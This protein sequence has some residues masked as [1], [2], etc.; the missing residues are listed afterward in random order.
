MARPK[1]NTRI[2]SQ[3]RN[4]RELERIESLLG[5]DFES[6]SQ[7]KAA[8][9]QESQP[10]KNS[11]TVRELS[12]RQNKTV[13]AFVS[14]LEKHIPEID[15]LKT[16]EDRWA[17]EIYGYKTYNLYSSISGLATQL[18]KYIDRGLGEEKPTKALKE[19][20]IIRVGFKSADKWLRDKQAEVVESKR[21]RLERYKKTGKKIRGMEKKLAASLKREKKYKAIIRKLKKKS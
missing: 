4:A 18:S 19:I 7:A 13:K 12:S 20:K 10:R 9:Q 14:D 8:L 3:L 1:K 5:E 6:L 15:S 2:K 17:A 21:K 11:Y 16:K